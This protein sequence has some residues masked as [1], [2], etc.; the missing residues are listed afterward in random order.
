MA[1]KTFGVKVSEELH[2]KVRLMIENSGDSAKEWFEKAVAVTELQSIKSGATDYNQ[3]LTELDIH[4]ARIYELISNMVQ[5][6][7]YIKDN[8]VKEVSDK[9]EQRESIIVEYQEKARI[10]TE[11]V[12]IIKESLKLLDQEKI[13]LGKQLESHRTTNENNQLL[14]NEYKEK[15]DTL[16]G[17]VTKYQ[18]FAKE[19]EELKIEHAKVLERMQSQVKE[20]MG[21]NND[22]QDEIKTL[23]QQLGSLKDSHEI[24]LERIN[25]KKDFEREKALLEVEREWQQKLTQANTE[26]SNTLKGLYEQMNEIRQSHEKEITSIRKEHDQKLKQSKQKDN[27]VNE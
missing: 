8:A 20:V 7:I 3:D 25:E 27:K 23:R 10:A 9:L 5:R 13:E 6:S 4:T 16:S 11:E 26:Y 12:N 24:E 17:L 15:N 19:N 18:S 22:Q 21:Q 2:E 1:D 14:I